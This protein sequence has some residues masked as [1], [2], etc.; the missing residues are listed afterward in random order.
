M[1]DNINFKITQN[2]VSG[3]NFLEEIPRYFEEIGSH[4]F[5][6]STVIT[7]NLNGFK[8]SVSKHGVSIKNG[9]LCKLYLGD[10]FQTLGREDTKK[11]IEQLSDTLHLPIDKAIVT[12]LDIAQNFIVKHPVDVYFN[13]LGE[14]KYSA[15][16]PVTK[17]KVIESLYYD[18]SKGLLIFYNKVKEQ[19]DKG[20]VIPK[21]Y[22]G[23]NALRYEQRYSQRLASTL[24]VECVSGSMLYD[25]AFYINVVNRW[26][27][28]YKAINKINDVTLNFGGMKTKRDLYTMGI[29]S[30]VK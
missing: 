1:Y 20:Y 26:R 19:K 11:A 18:Q 28:S 5:N 6:D 9:S 23:K 21:L 15:R 27:D 24:N 13:H 14:L 29:L 10:N 22:Q 8:I 3:I 25:E 30:L 4:N 12:R 2:E 17:G 16:F 7:G